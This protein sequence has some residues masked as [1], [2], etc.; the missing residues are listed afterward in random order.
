MLS[1]AGTTG[2]QQ[3]A[4]K[5]QNMVARVVRA[6]LAGITLTDA[7]KTKLDAVRQQYVPKFGTVAQAMPPI[8]AR[9]KAAREAKDTAALRAA[10]KDLITQRQQAMTLLRSTLAD[11]RAAL[12]ADHQ[13]RFDR[14]VVRVRRMIRKRFAP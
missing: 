3:T 4:Q 5:P 12:S 9:M 6:S 10:R 13:P 11:T 1:I 8:R 7:E 2:A 14:N